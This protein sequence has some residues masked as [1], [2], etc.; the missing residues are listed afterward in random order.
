MSL[1]ESSRPTTDVLDVFETPTTVS[2]P[3]KI[4]EPNNLHKFS[5]K[6]FKV[7]FGEF[8]VDFGD[9]AFTSEDSQNLV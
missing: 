3:N 8:K 1:I 7:Y 5:T 4:L 6:D 9:I 2:P